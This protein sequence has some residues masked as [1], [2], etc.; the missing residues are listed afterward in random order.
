M[1]VEHITDEIKQN[2]REFAS[3]CQVGIV[4]LGATIGDI[5]GVYLLEACRQLIS[6]LGSENSTFILLSHIPYLPNVGELK[7]MGCQRSV[8]LLRSKGI[9]PDIIIA[10]TAE[11]DAL[12]EYQMGKLHLYCEVPE[13]AVFCFPDLDDYYQIP[14]RIRSTL[15]HNYIALKMKILLGRDDLDDW[16]KNYFDE[17]IDLKIAILGKYPHQD[18][19]ISIINQ[20]NLFGVSS[21]TYMASPENL[22]DYDAVI[23]PGGWGDRGVEDM[24]KAAQICREE[25]IPCLGICLGLQVMDI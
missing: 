24:L 6:E 7:T 8:N 17:P 23:I 25:K 5:K 16:Y 21:I 3:Q 12:P 18:A 13:K 19:Y 10:R 9:K 22:T 14:R 15:M 1:S 11:H 4:E 20:L 2:L